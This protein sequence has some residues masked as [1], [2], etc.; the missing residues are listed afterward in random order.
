MV[1][2]S[3]KEIGNLFNLS[4]RTVESRLAVIKQKLNCKNKAQLLECVIHSQLFYPFFLKERG[5][6]TS[7]Y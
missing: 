4:A 2:S 1:R 6:T 7:Q 5:Q 3:A